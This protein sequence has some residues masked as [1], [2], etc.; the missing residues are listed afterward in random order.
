MKTAYKILSYAALHE[1]LTGKTLKTVD[2]SPETA[3]KLAEEFQRERG[4]YLCFGLGDVLEF[5]GVD[6]KCSELEAK[7]HKAVEAP[8]MYG[9][10]AHDAWLHS[11]L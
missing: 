5:E 7:T 6:I 8:Y 9:K 3:K 11:T 10:E 2:V 4:I 1:E